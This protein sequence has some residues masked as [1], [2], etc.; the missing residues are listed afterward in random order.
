MQKIN[1]HD[2]QIHKTH[3]STNDRDNKKITKSCP[4]YIKVKELYI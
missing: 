2:S 3:I 4:V 1:H